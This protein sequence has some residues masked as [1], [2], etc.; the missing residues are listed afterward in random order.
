M[1]DTVT[2]QQPGMATI[3]WHGR[4]DGDQFH[5]TDVIDGGVSRKELTGQ[6]MKMVVPVEAI[7]EAGGVFGL[8]DDD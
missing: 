8:P 7:E 1:T 4:R 6:A 5:V 2:F 3:L